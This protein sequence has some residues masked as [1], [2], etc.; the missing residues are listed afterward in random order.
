MNRGSVR[1]SRCAEC[2]GRASRVLHKIDV[3]SE[4]RLETGESSLVKKQLDGPLTALEN[5]MFS[6]KVTQVERSSIQETPLNGKRE[7]YGTAVGSRIGTGWK[8]QGS[9]GNFPKREAFVSLKGDLEWLK[10]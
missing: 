7:E 6:L 5:Q 4:S 1:G 2:P 3:L 8:D 10:Q 9:D